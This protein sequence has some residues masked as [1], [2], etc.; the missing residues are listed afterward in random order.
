MAKSS[1]DTNKLE[2]VQLALAGIDAQIKDLTEKRE[3]LK[4][5]IGPVAV[6]ASKRAVKVKKAVVKAAPEAKKK[7]VFS[8]ATRKKLRE[9][10][11]ARWARE[12]D[13]KPE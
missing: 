7:R 6:V 13:A 4:K 8:S 9:A 1:G 5:L 10:A 12:K 3:E 2:L 11:K